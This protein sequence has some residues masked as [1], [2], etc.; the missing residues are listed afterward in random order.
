MPEPSAAA[1]E[2][3]Y[4]FAFAPG[5][6]LPALLFGVLPRTTGVTLGPKGMRVRFG[7]WC[8]RTTIANIAGFETTGGFR[9]LKTAGPAHLS[10][11]DRGVTFATNGDAAVCVTFHTPVP[12][13]DPTRTIAHPSATITVAAP[14]SFVAHLEALRD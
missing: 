14:A 4:D 6:R 11:S 7:P 10:L 9:W 5:Y 1:D 2:T 12:G 3:R 13:I 8:L